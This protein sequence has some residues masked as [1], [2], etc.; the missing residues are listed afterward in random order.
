[1]TQLDHRARRA[2][3]DARTHLV[4]EGVVAAYINDIAR[5]A[6]LA[7]SHVIDGAPEHTRFT[8]RHRRASRAAR[9]AA[10]R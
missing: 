9:P 8:R 2:T 7:S 10:R 1:M 6:A 5:G 4:S 3:H